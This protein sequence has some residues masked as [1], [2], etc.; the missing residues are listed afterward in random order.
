M[1]THTLTQADGSR[2]K[3]AALFITIICAFSIGGAERAGASDLDGVSMLGDGNAVNQ[4]YESWVPSLIR[5]NSPSEGSAENGLV[6]GPGLADQVAASPP[7]E[8]AGAFSSA[9]EMARQ[10]SNPLGGDFY[11]LLNQFDNYFY[12][13]DITGETRNINTWAVQPVIPIKLGGDWIV[14]N[15]PTF[16]IILNAELP[17]TP[18]GFPPGGP[19]LPPD[20][21]PPG[22]P[23]FGNE[24]GFGDIV[25]FSLVGQSIPTE[26]FGG[27]DWVWAVG[28]T[29]QFPTASND[30]LGSEKYSAGPAGVGAFI[31]K[32]FILGGLS[33]NWIS[34]ASASG[35][36]D[37]N[38]VEYSWLN[39][40]YFLNFEGGWQVGGTPVITADWEADSDNRWS[41]PVGLGVYKTHFF[42]GKLPIKMGIESQYY[43]VQPD[44]YGPEWNIRFVFAPVIP[45][46]F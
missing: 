17:N 24:S 26:D 30:D 34:F 18:S 39:L 28:P 9:E 7:A 1:N 2:F 38:D 13:G 16:P 12:Q 19:P 31:G 23:S 25:H 35:G 11:I 6:K 14:V 46:L 33:Q 3:K 22:G 36:S 32:D 10:S 44:A 45:A 8:D 21:P 42:F 15:R 43:A 4:S 27:G 41:V 29:F 40:F 5:H 20:N 37:R